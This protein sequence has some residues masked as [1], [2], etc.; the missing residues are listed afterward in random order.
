[1]DIEVQLEQFV[2]LEGF[3]CP[4]EFWPALGYSGEAR[5]VGIWWEQCGDEA[6]W[7][8]GRSS[9]VGADWTSYLTLMKHNFK[10]G[11]KVKW[12]LGSS[13]EEAR[14]WLVVDRETEQGWLVPAA[15]A[16][17]VLRTQWLAEM[18]LSANEE[19]E[20]QMEEERRAYEALVAA[21]EERREA[22]E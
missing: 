2:R 11:D 3:V 20:R 21:L 19:V 7:C 10:A 22:N 5:Y 1:M 18:Y 9:V 13:E 4:A 8:D 6:S 17:A 16:G 14:C 12:L 15:G